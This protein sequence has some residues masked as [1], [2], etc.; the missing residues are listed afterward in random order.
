ML[1]WLAEYWWVILIVVVI[2]FLLLDL[3]FG[4]SNRRGKN[5]VGAALDFAEDIIDDGFDCDPFD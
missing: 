1:A 2:A 4:R 3:L 5:G